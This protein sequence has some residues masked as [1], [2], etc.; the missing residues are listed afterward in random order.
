LKH[1]FISKKT[2]KITKS[3]KE[4]WNIALKQLDAIEKE[5]K[6]HGENCKGA[7]RMVFHMNEMDKKSS[8]SAMWEISDNLTGTYINGV[9]CYP[10]VLFLCNLSEAL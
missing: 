5:A 9:K 4:N 7:F 6:L 2:C 10:G 3:I 1:N 8:W